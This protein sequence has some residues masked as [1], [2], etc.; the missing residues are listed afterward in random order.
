M[1]SPAS[2]RLA[3]SA[4]DLTRAE[5][6]DFLYEEAALLDEWKLAEWHA[7]FTEDATYR[8]PSTDVPEAEPAT[9][10]S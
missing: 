7:L 6:E 2:A 1:S 3:P 9:R 8:V 4:A 10:C 5:V